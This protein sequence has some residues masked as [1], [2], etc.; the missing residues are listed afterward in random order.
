MTVLAFSLFLIA[1]GSL[2]GAA[3]SLALTLFRRWS[4][5]RSSARASTL[6][7]LGVVV[8]AIAWM[9]ALPTLPD[10]V[11]A[12]PANKARLL[13]EGISEILNCSAPAVPALLLGGL[14]WLISARR[15]ARA[16]KGGA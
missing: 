3:V 11:S 15:I 1:I 8:L 14:A 13:A 4:L 16:S 12:S 2:V 5:A 7:A 10:L 9:V 6:T